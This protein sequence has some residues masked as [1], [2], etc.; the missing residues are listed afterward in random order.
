MPKGGR[1]VLVCEMKPDAGAESRHPSSAG[2]RGRKRDGTRVF[3]PSQQIDM[4]TLA[5]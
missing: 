2:V 5:R 1:Q 3:W 4:A